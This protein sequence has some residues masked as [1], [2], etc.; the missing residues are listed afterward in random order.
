[1]MKT[2]VFFGFSI[3]FLP[4]LLCLKGRC[5]NFAHP[6]IPA[7][8]HEFFYT[9]KDCLAALYRQDFEH[10]VPDHAIALVVTCVSI[11]FYQMTSVK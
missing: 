6:A 5:K 7:V 9:G 4:F 11:P 1:M 2:C 8:I 3:S 10:T